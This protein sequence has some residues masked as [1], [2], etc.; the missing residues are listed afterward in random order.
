MT[1]NNYT[2]KTASLRATR[3]D[4][5]NLKVKK[6]SIGD[7]DISKIIVQT[8]KTNVYDARGKNT[9]DSDLWSK[10]IDFQEDGSVIFNDTITIP[11][12]ESKGW[13]QD[14]QTVSSQIVKIEDKKA[15]GANNNL[16]CNIETDAI[17]DGTTTFYGVENNGYKSNIQTISSNFTSLKIAEEMFAENK[18]LTTFNGSLHNLT[19][20]FKMFVGCNKLANFDSDL[21]NLENGKQMFMNNTNLK[22]FSVKMPNLTDGEEMFYGTSLER[23]NSDTINLT[24]GK[25]MFKNIKTLKTVDGNFPELTDGEEMFSGTNSFVPSN[26]NLQSLTTAKNMFN[27]NTFECFNFDLPELNNGYGM[28]MLTSKLKAF[29]GDLSKLTNGAFMFYNV[30]MPTPNFEFEFISDLTNLQ[31]GYFMFYNKPLTEK[32]FEFI[33]E[34]I[35]DIRGITEWDSSIKEE[36][37]GIIHLQMIKD[38]VDTANIENCCN[39]IANKGWIVYL[40]STTVT[41]DPDTPGL[42]GI[43]QTDETTTPTIHYYKPVEVN[44]EYAEY[45]DGVSFYI[46]LGAEYVF[47]DDI[48][49]YGQFTSLN[50]AI[51][52]MG[53]TPYTKD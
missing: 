14:N 40:N 19:N 7:Q 47:G 31:T 17:T 3:A 28:F 50:D 2:T 33:S 42:E 11:A 35:N 12:D 45:T 10:K 16:V 53:L 44:Q 49:T 43:S 30:A 29:A 32:S 25:G 38:N 37:K 21:Y 9:T 41:Q 5:G 51:T 1:P 18:E 26:F 34:S 13:F 27:G 20:G 46:L 22:N 8:F 15:Y 52:Q 6:L 23:F 39:E 48:S 24:N 4:I 36:Q